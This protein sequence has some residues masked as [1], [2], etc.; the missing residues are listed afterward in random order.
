M[1]FGGLIKV[2]NYLL[3]HENKRT[4]ATTLSGAGNTS[5]G[6]TW[7]FCEN[8]RWYHL[9]EFCSRM[10]NSVLENQNKYNVVPFSLYVIAA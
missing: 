8:S 4:I 2:S 3:N 10:E 1:D 6:K 9:Y 7:V 5:H